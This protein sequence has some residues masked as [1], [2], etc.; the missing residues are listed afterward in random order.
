MKYTDAKEI[1]LENFNLF[2]PG[3]RRKAIL[4]YICSY[5]IKFHADSDFLADENFQPLRTKILN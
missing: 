4:Y 1:E 3:T 2:H 5:V